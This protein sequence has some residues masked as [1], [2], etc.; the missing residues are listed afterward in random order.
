MLSFLWY[1]LL[2]V[3]T[4]YSTFWRMGGVE[5]E[6]STEA[7]GYVRLCECSAPFY[8]GFYLTVVSY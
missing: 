7:K 2:D 6:K 8:L 1:F 5:E 4:S 3:F